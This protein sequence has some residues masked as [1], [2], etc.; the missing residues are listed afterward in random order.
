MLKRLPVFAVLLVLC[1][2]PAA[3]AWSL[4]EHVLLTRL[5]ILRLLDDPTTPQGLKIFLTTNTPDLTDIQGAR[6]FFMHGSVGIAPKGLVGTSHWSV[7]PDLRAG[8]KKTK[9]EPF[10]VPEQSLHF[11]DLELVNPNPDGRVYRHDLSSLPAMTE[12]PK[13]YKD[14]QYKDAGVLPFAV[15]RS[16]D[17]LVESFKQNRLASDPAKPDDNDHALR[18]A[19]AL[20]H[21]TQ[22][23]FQPH[24]ATVDYKSVSYF[25]DRRKAPNVHAEMEYKMNDDEKNPMPELRAEYWPVFEKAL[26]IGKD[27][28]VS[29]DPWAGS[30]EVSF[31]SYRLLPMIGL[32]AM[33]AAGQAGTSEKPVGPAG[34]F[35]TTKF[36]HYVG[37]VDGQ[38]MTLMQAKAQQQAGAVVRVARLLRQAWDEAHP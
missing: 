3:E 2:V 28:A 12:V 8:D 6:E 33:E 35:D 38:K 1:F 7:E 22:D 21:Y 26:Q 4:K 23:N 20:A 5:S 36:F 17:E 15:R 29:D 31:Y 25:A 14:P 34:E 19:G 27:P 11:I 32:A 30:L 18:W 13:D 24:H 10:G 37:E 16:Y 9:I